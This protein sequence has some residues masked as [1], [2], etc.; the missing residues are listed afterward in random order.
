LI[1]LYELVRYVSLLIEEA[2]GS[3]LLHAAATMKDDSCY[4]V[5][6]AKGAGKTTTMLHLVCDHGH[7]YFSGDKVLVTSD[8]KGLLIRGWPD[9]PHVGM[10]TFQRFPS[11]AKKCSVEL[12]GPDGRYKP[13]SQKVLVEPLLFRR[14]LSCTKQAATRQL[15][16]VLFPAVSDAPTRVTRLSSAQKNAIRMEEHIEYP[17]QFGTVHWHTL[18]SS[19]RRTTKKNYSGLFEQLS[20][21]TWLRVDGAGE[22]EPSMLNNMVLAG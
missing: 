7:Q 20:H 21:L 12:T 22:L 11:L 15:S 5:S 17:H 6:G 2:H 3:M 1:H 10:G 18:F 19:L 4:L 8:A 9:Y 16:L 14:A 13:L